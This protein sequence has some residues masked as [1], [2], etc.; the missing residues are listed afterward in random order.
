KMEG[1]GTRETVITDPGR[2]QHLIA[3]MNDMVD[4]GSISAAARAFFITILLTGMRRGEVQKLRWNQVDLA[5]MTIT[6]PT[7]KGSKLARSGIRS[8]TVAVPAFVTAVIKTLAAENDLEPDSL[9]FRPSR[10]DT[11]E[12]SRL[13]H[14][15]RKRAELPAGLTTH[16]LRHSIATR[17]A[18]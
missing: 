3:T 6:L 12:V 16:G 2:Y 9:V 14:R 18:L 7:S 5:T 8:E 17:A 15:I 11:L 10:G 13:W 1:D 4:E